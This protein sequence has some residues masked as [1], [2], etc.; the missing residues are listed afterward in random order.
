MSHAHSQASCSAWWRLAYQG[1]TYTKGP[2]FATDPIFPPRS[3]SLAAF[4]CPRGVTP[5]PIAACRTV[6]GSVVLFHTST[7]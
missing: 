1:F 6:G 5:A 4:L 7:Q 2:G 3:T